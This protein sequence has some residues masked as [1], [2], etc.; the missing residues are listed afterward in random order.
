MNNYEPNTPRAALG[1]V[2]AALTA[3]TIG[4]LVVA[5]A[6]LD[7]RSDGA[8][9]LAKATGRPAPIE[10]AIVP[11]RIDVTVVRPRAVT[12]APVH[13]HVASAPTPNVAWAMGD[14]DRPNCKPET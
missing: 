8:L 4:A 14:G 3:V 10:V 9:I 13:L 6:R 5:P 12:A 11:A 7:A 1:I 2:A